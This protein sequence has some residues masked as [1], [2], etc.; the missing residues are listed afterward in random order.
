MK[1]GTVFLWSVLLFLIG[2]VGGFLLFP[3]KYGIGN[4]S[5]NDCGNT[6]TR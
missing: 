4:H 3:L 5:G 6:Y 2:I 1:P